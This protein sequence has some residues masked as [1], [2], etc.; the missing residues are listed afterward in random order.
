MKK[1]LALT[2]LGVAMGMMTAAVPALAFR[3]G[4]FSTFVCYSQTSSLLGT[5]QVDVSNSS[6][7]IPFTKLLELAKAECNKQYSKDCGSEGACTSEPIWQ[8]AYEQWLQKNNLP[9]D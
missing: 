3:P 6:D 8:K 2:S 4:N 1:I 5:V 9:R 7:Y